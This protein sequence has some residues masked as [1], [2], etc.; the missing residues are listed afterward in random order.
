MQAVE[1]ASQT[2]RHIHPDSQPGRP[3]PLPMGPHP[4]WL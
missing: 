1:E 3:N 2:G 4:S